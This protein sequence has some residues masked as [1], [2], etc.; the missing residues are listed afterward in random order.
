METRN[1]RPFLLAAFILFPVLATALFLFRPD[2]ARYEIESIWAEGM[3]GSYARAINESGVV[4]GNIGDSSGGTLPFRWHVETGLETA[5]NPFDDSAWVF[6]LNETGHVVG[7]SVLLQPGKHFIRHGFVW[8]KEG[9]FTRL[10]PVSATQSEVA[11]ISKAGEIFGRIIDPTGKYVGSWDS[12]GV[13]TPIDHSSDASSEIVF[14]GINDLG[15]LVGGIW[16]G[17]ERMA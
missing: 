11:C 10:T 9:E 3:D 16:R 14:D 5:S 7:T 4:A 2:H 6:D 13:W 1:Y 8:K 12:S 17:D 15:Y